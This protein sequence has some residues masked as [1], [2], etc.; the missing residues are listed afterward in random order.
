MRRQLR[1]LLL[2]LCALLPFAAPH[3]HAATPTEAKALA[4]AERDH[5][6]YTLPPARLAKGESLANTRH[7]VYIA[8]TL[9]GF[10]TLWLILQFRIAARMRNVAVNLSKN[11]WA[12]GA[13]FLLQLGILLQL[14]DLPFSAFSHHISVVAGLSVQGWGSWFGDYLK[15]LS[16][17]G[18]V[19]YLIFMLAFWLIGKFQKTWWLW[20]SFLLMAFS[21][22][23]V[24]V[25]PYVIDPLFNK[26]EPLAQSNPA[27]VQQLERVVARGGGNIPPERMYLM[28]A[29]DKVTTLN[30]Y[31]T[32]FG[33][34][35][36]VVVWD[37]SIKA[38]KPDEVLFIFGHEMGHY[39][40]GHV[41]QGLLF[42]FLLILI[43][44]YLTYRILNLLIARYG[45][46][47]RIPQQHNW[48]AFVIFL[49]VVNVL[50]FVGSPLASAF[51]RRDEHAADVF[52]Q[53]A[54]QGIV[55]DPAAS[56]QAAFQLLGEN[57]YTVPDPNPLIEFWTDSHP[58]IWLRAAFA[59]HYN[60]Y[61]PGE[62]PKY[63]PR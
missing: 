36:R 47:W 39:V 25:V 62:A 51:S 17:T 48:A 31:V 45:T 7:V 12:Q 52:G 26:F 11:R 19:G 9:W 63:L 58:P 53:E 6:A 1:T 61:A 5:T 13:V 44:M 4:A 22:I 35:K 33:A 32:G 43:G 57:S 50:S 55:A 28:K 56:A 27:L 42:S 40:L 14:L 34:S 38:G 41:V 49:L 24:L 30:A 21:L 60:P 16:L 10:L 8:G 15:G 3:A 2:I 20:F 37:T 46:Q 23:G 18:V 54:I 59:R 29:S